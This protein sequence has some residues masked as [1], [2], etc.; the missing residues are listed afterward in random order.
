MTM[1]SELH[2]SSIYTKVN[3][4]THQFRVFEMVSGTRRKC[5]SSFE[6]HTRIYAKSRV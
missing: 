5:T 3:E 2:L 6:V 1:T 4:K